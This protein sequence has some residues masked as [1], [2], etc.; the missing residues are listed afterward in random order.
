MSYVHLST[1]NKILDGEEVAFSTTGVSNAHFRRL[2]TNLDASNATNV[3]VLTPSPVG[4]CPRVRRNRPH[5]CVP[6]AGV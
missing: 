4:S 2:V 3:T 5:A 6:K 1:R